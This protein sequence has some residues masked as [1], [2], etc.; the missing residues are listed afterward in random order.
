MFSLPK[1]SKDQQY[2][3][4][5]ARQEAEASALVEAGFV[6]VGDFSD[7]DFQEVKILGTSPVNNPSGAFST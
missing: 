6:C 3:S 2:V 5:V 4:K 7:A 1:N